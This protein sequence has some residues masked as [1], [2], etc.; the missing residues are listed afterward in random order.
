MKKYIIFAGVNGAGKSTLFQTLKKYSG[1]NRVNSDEI[2]K[3]FGSWKNPSDVSKAGRIAVSRIKN[4][5]GLGETFNQE[6]TL[7]GN[8]IFNNI[9]KCK[10]SGYVI[11]LHYVGVESVDIAKKRIRNR[12]NNGGH[13]IPDSDVERRFIQSMQN[14]IKVIPYTDIT[15]LYDNTESF[16]RFAIYRNGKKYL[17]S[18]RTPEWYNIIQ[19]T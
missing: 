2:V 19:N 14:L 18:S 1:M 16:R 7:C 10:E 4:Y 5:I 15:I 13:G 12:V 11:E 9:R 3:E 17:V 6:T 8:S